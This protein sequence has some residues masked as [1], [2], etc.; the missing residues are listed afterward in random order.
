MPSSK[1]SS[2]DTGRRAPKTVADLVPDPHNRRAHPTRNAALIAASLKDVGPARSIVIDEDNVVHAGNGVVAG[3][4]AAGITKLKI[5][6]VDGETLVAV[7]R[8]GL[9]AEQK[10]RL[11][12]YD[13]RTA[14]LAEWN[15][16]Q[17]EADLIDGTDLSAFFSEK[18]LDKLLKRQPAAE[19]GAASE[20]LAGQYLVVLTCATEAEQVRLLERF[21]AEGLN[22]K[23]LVS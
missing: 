9:S 4:L 20:T 18:E 17:L 13:N 6:D 8:S 1:P 16:P 10:T 19:A 5:V 12:L 3:A 7:R 22:C 21:T 2:S 14:E 23:A 15:V 11:A